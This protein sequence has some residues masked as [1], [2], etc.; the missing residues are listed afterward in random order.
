MFCEHANEV[1]QV[2]PCT[3][4]D[5]YCKTHTCKDRGQF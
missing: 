5:C 1:P 4:P 3:G 2:C